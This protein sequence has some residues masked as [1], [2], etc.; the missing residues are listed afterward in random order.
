MKKH[1]ISHSLSPKIHNYWFKQNDI[2][3][4]YEKIELER[5]QVE[6][7]LKKIK[8]GEIYGMNVTVPFKQ[9]VIPF[10]ETLSETAKKTYSVNTI[11]IK[12]GKLH[13][14][15]TDVYG[16]ENSILNNK[17][18]IENKKVLIFGSGGVVPSIICGLK[19]LKVKKIY[20]SNRTIEKAKLIK[21]KFD[22]VEILDWGLT[23]NC[24]LIINCTSVGLK[25]N[26]RLELDYDSLSGDK[27]FYDVIYNP[28]M[29][30]FLIDAE[31][32]GYK[33]IN[34][35]DMF[36]YQAQKAFSLWHN[37]TPEIDENLINHLYND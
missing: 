32:L 10:I 16:F 6:T 26:E 20:V 29:T 35:R 4:I 11:Y 36:L 25:K 17:I 14:D 8:N 1:I 19:N 9:I 13:G 33:I 23:I 34:G 37:I 3:A 24:D 18:N 7:F 15:N 22:F 2:N 30:S 28:Q 5:E 31:K 27:I 12:D 21:K